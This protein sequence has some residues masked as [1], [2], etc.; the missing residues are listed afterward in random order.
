MP[1]EHPPEFPLNL[2]RIE[3]PPLRQQLDSDSDDSPKKS[4]L[5]QAGTAPATDIP[6]FELDAGEF[7]QLLRGLPAPSYF[8]AATRRPGRALAHWA[9]HDR[10][11]SFENSI[12]DNDKRVRI[13]YHSAKHACMSDAS[14]TC[15]RCRHRR[16]KRNCCLGWKRSC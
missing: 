16:T 8:R 2:S 3:I 14:T 5:D 15:I 10:M 4:I 12:F 1:A 9:G 6:N 7:S 11:V 13:R